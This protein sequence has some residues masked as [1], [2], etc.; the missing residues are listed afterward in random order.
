M[1]ATLEAIAQES[2]ARLLAYIAARNGHDI[3]AAEDALADAFAN[4]LT[5]W[6]R[7]GVPDKPEAWLLKAARNRLI[8][9]ARRSAV[10]DRARAAVARNVLVEPLDDLTS[11]P[12]ERLQ[13]MFACAH[14]AIDIKVRT[15]L[16][17]QVVLGLS[18]EA[19]AAAFLIPATTMS[20][21]LVRAKTKIRDAGIAFEMP[22]PSQLAGRL[23]T[24]LDAIYAVYGSSW[25]GLDA[26]D[27]DMVD[28]A[29]RLARIV[30]EL[31][32]DEPE[33]IG[34]LSLLLFCHARRSSR[35]DR[36]GAFVPLDEQPPELWYD[37]EIEEAES[38]LQGAARWSLPGRYQLEAAIQSAHMQR[39]LGHPIP[40][41][42]ILEMY[43]ALAIHSPT[44]GVVVAQ[45]AAI[46][47]AKSSAEALLLLDQLEPSEVQSYQPYWAVRAHVLCQL[48]HA[49]ALQAFDQAIGL[50]A[51]PATRAFLIKR[52]AELAISRLG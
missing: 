13:L 46:A 32:P 1:H 47:K 3:A 27:R 5:C 35:R 33:G 44:V 30:V 10:A 52:R 41:D 21:R 24:V 48:D 43:S 49:D 11:I 16:L 20:Q 23:H 8:D 37:Q 7:D 22:E 51:D 2:Y 19:I 9:A 42:A 4:A 26:K 6:L 45:A 29:I 38:L 31:L 17:L 14:P 18:S 36:E 40:W 12:D 15:P 25:D 28:E 39:H 34:L 50:C